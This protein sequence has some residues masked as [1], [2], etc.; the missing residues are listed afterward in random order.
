VPLAKTAPR[1]HQVFMTYNALC[2]THLR[3]W[4]SSHTNRRTISLPLLVV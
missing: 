3:P 2:R 4:C 1:D